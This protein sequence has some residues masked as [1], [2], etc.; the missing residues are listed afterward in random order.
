MLMQSGI[1]V[2]EKVQFDKMFRSLFQIK[3][4]WPPCLDL[5]S[6]L[7]CR[8]A[9]FMKVWVWGMLTEVVQI[10]GTAIFNCDSCNKN[11]KKG[12]K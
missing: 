11:I 10:S 3:Q 7:I 1:F 8:S 12:K 2:G 6:R 4:F 5:A 9:G